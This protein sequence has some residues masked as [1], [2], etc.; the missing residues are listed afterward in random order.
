MNIMKK[1]Q[2]DENGCK[3]ILFRID[4]YFSECFLAVEID[5]KGHTDRDIIFEEKRQKAL[6]KKLGC[7]FIRINTSNAKN[8]YDLDY[9]VGNVQAF[10]DE[11]KNKKIK[12]LEK[13]LIKEKEMREKLEREMREK[14]ENEMREKLEEELKDKNKELKNLSTTKLLIILEKQK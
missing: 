8:G 10:I 13:Q 4:I 3:Y 5:E 12:K 14:V 6:E 2:A 9:E 7:K 11:F 1:I